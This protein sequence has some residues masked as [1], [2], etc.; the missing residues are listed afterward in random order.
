MHIRGIKDQVFQDYKKASMLIACA[1]CTFKCQ[2]QGLCDIGACQNHPL[3][4]SP[5]LDVD[6]A[7]IVRRYTSNPLT[8]AIIIGGFEPMDQPDEL[9]A[10]IKQFRKVTADDI[11]IFTGYYIHQLRH[12]ADDILNQGNIIVKFGRY[13]QSKPPRYDNVLGVQLASSNQYAVKYQY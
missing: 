9:L 13:D 1:D 2:K 6:D 10:L 3:M 12:I 7:Q 4:D 5:I 8:H 11:V